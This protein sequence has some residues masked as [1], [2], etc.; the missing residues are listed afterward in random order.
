MNLGREIQGR[1]YQAGVFGRRPAVPTE[2][3][4]LEVAA[5]RAMSP[6]AWSYVA[7]GAGQQ[8]TVAANVAAFARRR[9]VPRM[10]VDVAERDLGVDLGRIAGG[11]RWPVPLALAP[12][13]VLEMAHPQAEHAVARAAAATG[14]PMVLSTQ[15]SVPM[16]QVVPSLGSTPRWFQLYWSRDEDVVASFLTRAEAIGAEAIVVTLDTHLLGWRTHDLDLAYL[17]FARA[18]GIAQYTSDP[19]FRRLV[20]KR[21]PSSE[22]T[23]RPTL[24]AVRALVS[25]ARHYPGPLLANLRSSRPRAAVETFLDVF[26]RSDLTW[27]DLARLREMTSLPILVKGLQHRDDARLALEHGVDGIVVSNHGGRQVDNAVASLDA[28]PGI[29]E[30]VA[31]RVPVLFDSGVRSGADVAVA[32][33]LGAD[34]VLI[35]RPY[36]YGLALAGEAGVRTVLE[37]IIA[38]LDLTLALSGVARVQDLTADLLDG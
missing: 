5:H 36:V 2:P 16:E 37:S 24:A 26:S 30:E 10:F 7:G 34:A 27:D 1:I 38:E 33:A 18:E 11:R 4:A 23:P 29:A 9:I 6:Q 19:V 22:P 21:P 15:A 3:V 32:L 14:V 31:G 13:G 25:M 8:R 28:L 17:P 20:D 12:I 35:G